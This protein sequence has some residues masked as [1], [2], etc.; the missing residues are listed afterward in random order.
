MLGQREGARAT[1]AA[2]HTNA[3]TLYNAAHCLPAASVE[4]PASQASTHPTVREAAA[5]R[6]RHAL[7]SAA[8]CHQLADGALIQLAGRLGQADVAGVAWRG[9]AAE[10]VSRCVVNRC[11]C[12]V[13]HVP[14]GPVAA[15]AGLGGRVMAR[16][17]PT[18]QPALHS[19][20]SFPASSPAQSGRRR[21]LDEVRLAPHSVHGPVCGDGG[22]GTR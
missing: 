6:A 12:Q 13:P 21:Q 4:H 5:R 1:R 2:V 11:M 7:E 3:C 17:N 16:C 19:H 15:A 18:C 14:K 20:P 22:N 8:G 9:D 10:A